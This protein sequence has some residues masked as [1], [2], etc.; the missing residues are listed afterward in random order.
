MACV[1]VYVLACLRASVVVEHRKLAPFLITTWLMPGMVEVEEVVMAE[2]EE[3]T[4][5]NHLVGDIQEEI[6]GPPEAME[7]GAMVVEAEAVGAG[8]VG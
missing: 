2:A 4:T 1:R 6:V 3:A 7:E 8:D 5:A